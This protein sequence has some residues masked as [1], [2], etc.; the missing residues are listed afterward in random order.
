MVL[1]RAFPSIG[2]SFPAP[3]CSSMLSTPL[4]LSLSRLK[5]WSVFLELKC[6]EGTNVWLTTFNAALLKCIPEL[7]DLYAE[8]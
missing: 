4:S 8:I 2:P 1:A 5:P 3:I 7:L 6:T